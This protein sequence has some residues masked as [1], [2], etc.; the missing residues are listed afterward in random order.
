MQRKWQRGQLAKQEAEQVPVQ[1]PD[2]NLQCNPVNT[3][4]SMGTMH[5]RH[6]GNKRE[7]SVVRSTEIESRT[8]KFENLQASYFQTKNWR[9]KLSNCKLRCKLNPN[10]WPFKLSSFKFK[11]I[12]IILD[13]SFSE[14]DLK[15]V[16]TFNIQRSD[17][18]FQRGDCFLGLTTGPVLQEKCLARVS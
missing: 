16:L 18:M 1:V 3:L 11:L 12:G 6:V 5:F 8:F 7:R 14:E 13:C 10:Y 4:C 9:L 17:G 15:Q 2:W